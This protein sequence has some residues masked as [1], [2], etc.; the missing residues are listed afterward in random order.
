MTWEY[1]VVYWVNRAEKYVGYQDGRQVFE[2]SGTH[3]S[4]LL[5]HLGSARWELVHVLVRRDDFFY[6]FKRPR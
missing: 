4:G 3:E 6:Y 1:L 5:T 2:M